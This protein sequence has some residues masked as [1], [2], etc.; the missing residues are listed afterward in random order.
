VDGTIDK[1]LFENRKTTLL[2]EQKKLEEELT[3]LKDP[4]RSLPETLS[5]FLERANSAYLCYEMGLPDEKRDLLRTVTS[6]RQ[7]DRKQLYLTLSVP[8]S[9]VG[10]RFQDSNCGPH[11][12]IP[13]TWDVLLEKLCAWLKENPTASAVLSWNNSN[14][15]DE[16]GKEW[17]L[18]A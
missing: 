12:D 10:N 11:R 4:S 16:D 6:N 13:R 14:A 18:A 5:K 7:V 8:F 3:V 17:K 15:S 1:A 9:L 2:M